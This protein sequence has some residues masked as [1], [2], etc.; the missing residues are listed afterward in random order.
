MGGDDVRMSI[1]T[2]R[3]KELESLKNEYGKESAPAERFEEAQWWC[4]NFREHI[5]AR[6]T[7][8][9]QQKKKGKMNSSG[10][11]A[12]EYELD[13]LLAQLPDVYDPTQFK[14]G[15]TLKP[16]K[17]IGLGQTEKPTTSKEDL[18][19]GYNLGAVREAQWWCENFRMAIDHILNETIGEGIEPMEESQV[20]LKNAFLE[21]SALLAQL[22]D[23]QSPSGT[24]SVIR[25]G[26]DSGGSTPSPADILKEEK[27]G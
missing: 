19:D 14:G 22:P 4:E 18:K 15:D 20:K 17:G 11:N 13:F 3:L 21:L 25:A 10:F 26:C 16:M 8:I 23:V 6:K 12:D 1:F 7:Y 5:I 27:H 24:R 2:E 9:I